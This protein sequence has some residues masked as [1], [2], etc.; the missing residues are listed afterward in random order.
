MPDQNLSER[1]PATQ[2]AARG[3]IASG[4]HVT[5]L[6]GCRIGRM[7]PMVT[8]TPASTRL[9]ATTP[10]TIAARVVTAASRSGTTHSPGGSTESVGG[11]AALM[12]EE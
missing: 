1:H 8:S 11:D 3:T 4:A 7:M 9:I 12:L 2:H 6:P 5:T 10:V